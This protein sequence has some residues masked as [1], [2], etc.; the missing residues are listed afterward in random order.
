MPNNS[1][2]HA[3]L[4][5]TFRHPPPL[6]GGKGG[7]HSGQGKTMRN[8]IR[9]TMVSI[10]KIDYSNYERGLAYRLFFCY[11]FFLFL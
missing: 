4:L 9:N 5:S 8:T 6:L 3:T 7:G 1:F 2:T 11:F 10:K